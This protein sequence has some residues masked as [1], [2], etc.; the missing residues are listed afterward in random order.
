MHHLR[1]I[2]FLCG[3]STFAQQPLQEPLKIYIHSKTAA[4]QS[5]HYNKMHFIA[6]RPLIVAVICIA[7][8]SINA[9]V[10]PDREVCIRTQFKF[11][12]NVE[13]AHTLSRNR[14]LALS[15]EGN[16]QFSERIVNWK[17]GG[18]HVEC[19]LFTKCT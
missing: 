13:H 10:D 3:A 4:M 1:Y 8:Y 15:N 9:F 7:C 11:K 16:N 2:F 18:V 6:A 12:T 5:E 17:M 19:N 14:D